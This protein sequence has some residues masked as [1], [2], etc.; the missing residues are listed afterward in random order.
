MTPAM[1][2]DF[3]ANQVVGVSLNE[4]TQSFANNQGHPCAD[5]PAATNGGIIINTPTGMKTVREEI[6]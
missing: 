1:S 4:I 3:R 5:A 6:S 2:D